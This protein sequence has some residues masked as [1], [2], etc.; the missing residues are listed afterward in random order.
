M[1]LS[2]PQLSPPYILSPASSINF[3]FT[4]LSSSSFHF[5]FLILVLL[6]CCP[7]PIFL[8]LPLLFLLYILFFLPSVS[9][10]INVLPSQIALQHH[11]LFLVCLPPNNLPTNLPSLA[12]PYLP[13][14]FYSVTCKSIPSSFYSSSDSPSLS[15][16]LFIPFP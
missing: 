14:L 3:P 7:F 15:P 6:F 10:T 4:F 5:N 16:N 1:P 8:F 13:F 2:L 11:P 9:L 12:I